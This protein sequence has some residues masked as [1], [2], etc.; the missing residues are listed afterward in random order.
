MRK[1]FPRGLFLGRNKD[2]EPVERV[3]GWKGWI[4][5]ILIVLVSALVFSFLIKTFLFKTFFVP[6]G[7]MEN[8][9]EVGDRVVANVV[10]SMV[11]P[12]QRGD[13]IVF[14]D[15]Q[16]WLPAAEGPQENAI[17]AG[18][19]YAGLIPDNSSRHLVKRVIGIAGDKVECCN[20][21][22]KVRVNGKVI[23]ESYLNSSS[24]P[25][26]GSSRPFSI[27]VPEGGM[28]VM[29]DNRDFSADSRLHMDSPSKG[30]IRT[31]DIV[32]TVT[33]R[34]WPLDRFGLIDSA[35]EVFSQ[36]P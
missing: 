19:E 15:T 14:K 18:M 7:S 29:G 26:P 32:G 25:F 16:G 33:L 5:E 22:G 3:T 28:W 1:I 36:I 30:I 31:D 23:E 35:D 13:I 21:D 24:S 10:G 9:L 4:K 6:S 8:T 17:A 11:F 34:A 20:T 2:D 27:I 12:V